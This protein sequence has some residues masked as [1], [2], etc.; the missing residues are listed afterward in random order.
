MTLYVISY[1]LNKKKD[2]PK[3]WKALEDNHAHRVLESVWLM[4]VKSDWTPQKVCEW[5]KGFVD[6]D[7]SIFVAKTTKADIWYTNAKSGTNEW[8]QNKT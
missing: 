3:L 1:D 8:L 7:D 4:D 6:G 2:Y 5:L